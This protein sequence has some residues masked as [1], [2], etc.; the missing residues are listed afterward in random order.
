[1]TK[2]CIIFLKKK[3]TF[4]AKVYNSLILIYKG[5]RFSNPLK[6][7]QALLLASSKENLQSI[8]MLFVFFPIDAIWLDKNKR[9]IHIARNI[10]PFTL[11]ITSPKKAQY[12]L[13]CPA[14]STQQIR[15]NTPLTFSMK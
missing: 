9:I 8:D 4:T 7:H 5:L 13:E 14:N 11:S 3:K 12:I 10:R 6:K 15:I 1:M 2:E